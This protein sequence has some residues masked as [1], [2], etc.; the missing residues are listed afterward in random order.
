MS[1][2]GVAGL[3]CSSSARSL[4]NFKV[5]SLYSPSKTFDITAIIVFRVT[6]DLPLH[7]VPSQAG[8]SHLSGIKLTDPDFGTPGKIDLL[9]GVETFVQ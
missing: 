3:V 9:L 2:Y 5:S 8:W 7:P 1:C 4:T 6:C